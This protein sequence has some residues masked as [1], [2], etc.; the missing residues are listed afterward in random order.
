MHPPR[1]S[2]S[3]SVLGVAFA[4]GGQPHNE[5][6]VRLASPDEVKAL[7]QP[8]STCTTPLIFQSLWMHNLNEWFAPLSQR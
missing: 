8:F 2:L 7:R 5:I 1:E 4:G 6:P 3:A